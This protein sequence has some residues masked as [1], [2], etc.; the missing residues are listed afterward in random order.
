[1][2][3]LCINDL[4]DTCNNL[5]N[6]LSDQGDVFVVSNRLHSSFY[7]VNLLVDGP[8]LKLYK[9]GMGIEYLSVIRCIA[10]N[11]NLD[12]CMDLYYWNN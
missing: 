11:R 2:V 4:C 10:R 5:L 7:F 12:I 6:Y 9:Q 8:C 1:M 3:L